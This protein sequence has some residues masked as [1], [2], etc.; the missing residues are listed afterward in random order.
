M[1]SSGL[2]TVVVVLLCLLAGGT[3]TLFK[4]GMS[5]SGWLLLVVTCSGVGVGLSQLLFGF[6]RFSRRLPRL[7]A[8]WISGDAGIVGGGWV[9]DAT[10]TQAAE[11]A[12][13]NFGEVGG[14]DFDG[15]S[16]GS[17]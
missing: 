7:G 8:S 17:G 6:I 4:A 14:C 3:M 2:L 11:G 12:V 1:R 13:E 9:G 15:D 10:T 5:A 16:G